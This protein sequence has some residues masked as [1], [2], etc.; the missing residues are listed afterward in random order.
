MMKKSSKLQKGFSL[1]E[2]ILVMSIMAILI[3]L[4]TINLVGSQQKASLNTVVENLI[5]DV[6]QQQIKAMIGD[7]QGTANADSYGVHTDFSKYVLFKGT[8]Y[9]ALDA[10][11]FEV[12][13]PSNIQ[14]ISPSADTIFLRVSGEISSVASLQVQDTTNSNIKTIQINRYG[15]ITGV[16]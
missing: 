4:I 14:F 8:S 3:G 13:L 6:R 10:S 15:V 9:D 16:N 7:S 11:N 5:S 1:V 2:L 12:S